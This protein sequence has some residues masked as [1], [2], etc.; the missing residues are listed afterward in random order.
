MKTAIII[1][2]VLLFTSLSYAE[3]L[4]GVPTELFGIKLGGIY[5]IGD[6]EKNTLGNIPIKKFTG[7]K[8]FLGQGIHY[9]FQ[10]MKEYKAFEYIEKKEDP[11]NQYYET[12][13]R[14]YM[15]PI[16]PHSFKKIEQLE[17]LTPKWEVAVIE[18]SSE[19]KTK[20]DAYYWAIDICKTFE[21]D[22]NLKPEI[23][24]SY[25][26]KWYECIF[27]TGSREFKASSSYSRSIQLSYI[28][29]VFDKKNDEVEKI[30]HKIKAEE[31]RPY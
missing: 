19:A 25:E 11:E 9:F 22:I 23:I 5:E 17:K 20:D 26:Q 10:P 1:V 16:I 27:S 18:W 24:N 3:V 6:S 2:S 28:K 12:S 29:K 14:L 31:I 8:R 15:L 4:N 13:F 30:I 7:M 21:T